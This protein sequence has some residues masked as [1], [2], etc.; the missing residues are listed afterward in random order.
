MRSRVFPAPAI[1]RRV[2][3]A[4]I[5]VLGGLVVTMDPKRTVLIDG[6]IAVRDGAIVAL[7]PR[8][9]VEAEH[10]AARVIEACDALIIPGLIDAHTHM[11]MTLFRGLADDLPLH[12]WLEKHVWPAERQFIH[13]ET[14]RWGSRLGV[15]ELLR[16]GVTTFCD[17]Y[18]YEGEVAT[19]VDELGSR[20]VLGQAFF[21]FTSP[22]GLDVEHNV[23]YAEQFIARWRGHPRIVPALAPHA[24]YTVSPDLYRR[25]HALAERHDVLL[26]THVAET[27]DED[28]DVRAR[29]GRSPT[30][31]LANLGLVDERLVAAHCVWVDGEEIELLAAGDAGVVHNP[32]SNL[33]LGSGI[34]PVPDLLRAGI[35]VGLG[36]DGAASNNELDLFAE[37]QMAALI[38][39]GVR[40][41][42]LAVPAPVALEMATIGGAR[43]LRLEHLV[44]SLEVGKRADLAIIDLDK[45]NL[46]PLYDP[47]SHLAY[48]VESSDVRTVLVDGRVVLEDGRLTT[49]DE[50]EIRRRIRTLA[51]EIGSLRPGVS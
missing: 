8:D 32:R 23:S 35:R 12:T 3:D 44:G 18:F 41:D 26:L 4:D 30:R 10:H 28:R 38:H 27:R 22:Q 20:A 6:A 16:S 1:R 14:V 9:V 24:P 5:V 40:L 2:Q 42:P 11:P 15:A 49:A 21:D 46:V 36:T 19:V 34:A 31:H 29:Y 43:V 51:T 17:M 50:R 13:P 39:K 37:I 25:L 48:A 33:K 45:D 7:G 47:L